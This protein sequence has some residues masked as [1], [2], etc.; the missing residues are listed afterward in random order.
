MGLLMKF[1]L[2]GMIWIITASSARAELH[3]NQVV[4]VANGNSRE[5]LQVAEHYALRRGIPP[6]QIV[7][8]DLPERETISR[9]EYDRKV[10]GPLRQV[11]QQHNLQKRVRVL[12]TVYGVPLHVGPPD[13][14][15]AEGALRRDAT[16]KLDA[17]RAHLVD[18]EQQIRAIGIPSDAGATLGKDQ[19]PKLPTYER[20]MAL[21]FRANRAVL[22][23]LEWARQHSP[24][25]SETYARLESLFRLYKGLAGVDELQHET[26][27]STSV[28]D[29]VQEARRAQQR[30]GLQL[31]VG[32]LELPIRQNRAELYQRIERVY[33]PY[34]VFV[35][36]A[37]ELEL[38]SDESGDA[39][40]DS[41][42]GLLWW[43]RGTYPLAWRHPNPFHH[44]FKASMPAGIRERP[45]LMVSRLDAS[46]AELATKLVDRAME[47]EHQGLTG[48]IYLD[49]QGIPA[50][51][52]P[53]TYTKYDQSLQQLHTFIG[54]HSTY[55]S[56][57]ENTKARFERSGQAPDVALY[58]G[59][60]R[61][62]HY[63][64]AFTFQPGAIGYHMASAEA[65]SLHQSGETGWCKNALEHGITATLGSVGEPYLDAFPEPL[66]F[67][68][69]LMTGQYSL[70]EA[71][72][73]TSRWVSWRMVLIGD[74]LY[75]PW[76]QKPAIKRSALSMFTL[77]PM[78]P[79]DQTF[80]DPLRAQEERRH[81]YERA[82]VRL[83][84]ILHHQEQGI[85]QTA[86]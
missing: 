18:V 72:A 78:A 14:T 44:A 63:E 36:A 83:D 55:R 49:A 8:L 66:E 38:L 54:E 48:T 64:D 35:L 60:Y 50:K 19:D 23:S 81:L 30:E 26:L 15:E 25:D 41:E 39:S 10:V 51:E 65:V 4:I 82:R 43:E 12:V 3:P 9:A 85:R 46:T 27:Q 62:R 71:Y 86:H 29:R 69:L 13:F 34:G 59:W 47:A 1:L 24:M 70:V 80:V 53:D 20:N 33:G 58:V 40:V 77:A 61:L 7:K 21:L 75:N 16:G 31:L 67:T 56:I 76:K 5:S 11:L 42:L 32:S 2:V 68:A 22:S 45:V 57:L 79:S 37:M 73:L 28:S 84:D 52:S 74:P 6:Q 17:A